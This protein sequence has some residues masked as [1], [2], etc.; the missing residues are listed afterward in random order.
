M[1]GALPLGPSGAFSTA[2]GVRALT[3][4][5]AGRFYVEAGALPQTPTEG[6]GGSVDLANA[7]VFVEAG[8]L[9]QTPH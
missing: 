9:P 3:A 8:A 6:G 4:A 7:G 5:P 1:H 2:A